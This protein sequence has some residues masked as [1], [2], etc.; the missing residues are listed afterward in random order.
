MGSGL[1]KNKGIAEMGRES[2]EG[3]GQKCT[4]KR[5]GVLAS[6]TKHCDGEKDGVEV[7]NMGG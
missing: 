2:N 1:R 3:G 5:W 7:M 4:M 6:L